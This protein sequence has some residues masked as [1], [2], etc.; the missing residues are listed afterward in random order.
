MNFHIVNTLSR[1]LPAIVLALAAAANAVANIPYVLVAHEEC[2]PDDPNCCERLRDCGGQGQQETFRAHI[3]HGVAGIPTAQLEHF[4]ALPRGEATVHIKW[5][6]G[7]GVLRLAASS[8]AMTHPVTGQNIWAK[9]LASKVSAAPVDAAVNAPLEAYD[10][11][12]ADGGVVR[13]MPAA[14]ALI[15]IVV[16]GWTPAGYVFV[17]YTK[18]GELDAFVVN[19]QVAEG[20][21]QL[22]K[23]T[24][25]EQLPLGA[26]RPYPFLALESSYEPGPPEVLGMAIAPDGRLLKVTSD[27]ETFAA[28]P[29]MPPLEEGT[30]TR[31]PGGLEAWGLGVATPKIFHHCIIATGVVTSIAVPELEG[32]ASVAVGFEMP[33][34]TAVALGGA[35]GVDVVN[36]TLQAVPNIPKLELPETMPGV[37]RRAAAGRFGII[38]DLEAPEV[39]VAEYDPTLGSPTAHE[40]TVYSLL[41]KDSAG[42]PAKLGSFTPY[43]G[44]RGGVS[45]ARLRGW[46]FR[47]ILV[48]SPGLGMQNG[49]QVKVWDLSSIAAPRVLANFFAYS[50]LKYGGNVAAGDFDGDGVDEILTGAGGGAVFGPHVR[51]FRFDQATKRVTAMPGVSFFAY[52]TLKYGVRVAAGDLDGDGRDEIVTGPGPG[53]TFGAQIRA[54]KLEGNS[55]KPAGLNAMIATGCQGVTPGVADVDGNGHAEIFAMLGVDATDTVYQIEDG[56]LIGS[57]PIAGTN[58][59]V[60]WRLEYGADGT[61]SG[62][63]PGGWSLGHRIF[64]NTVTN[65]WLTYHVDTGTCQDEGTAVFLMQV[66]VN[67][68]SFTY[69]ANDDVTQLGVTLE[70]EAQMAGNSMTGTLTL[71]SS[72][73][74]VNQTQTFTATR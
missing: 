51:A 1:A 30:F 55:V 58:S 19:T 28:A 13:Y 16:G 42:R 4:E 43:P 14:D 63:S 31:G 2:P 44:A 33:S 49:P 34:F 23:V 17:P 29:P 21:W 3:P 66:P 8:M 20:L 59:A 41:L 65:A 40:V 61:W 53:A 64:A 45:L 5:I 68:G 54:F 52:Q 11:L 36:A 69:V 62:S 57:M 12:L 72:R 35:V 7:V 10:I 24:P 48:T 46:D 70:V 50:T 56:A 18:T 38:A 67:G 9:D 26:P 22:F 25:S 32:A 60:P 74:G 27:G 15:P 73:C 71:S 47:D 6:P 39:A 37:E